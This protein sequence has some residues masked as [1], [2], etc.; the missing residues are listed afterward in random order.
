M[1]LAAG[2]GTR[3]RPLTDHT[4]KALLDVGGVPIIERVAR[5]L[6][7]A[8]A[9]R[10]II[11]TAH[12][13]EQIEAYVRSRDGFGVEAVFSR[14][15]PGP[16]ETG[17][18]LLV[19]QEHF[20]GDAPFFLHNA[21]ILSDIPLG[22]VHAAHRAAGDPL[23]TVAVLDRPTSRKLLFDDAGLLGR[24]DEGKGLDLRVRPPV[25]Q[26]AAI[27]FAGIHVISPRIFGLLTERGAFS[28]LDPYL[29]LADAGERVLPFR[30]DGHTWI[31]IGRPEQ[32]EQARQKFG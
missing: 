23:A 29:R 26:V 13:A 27:P 20:R 12:L 25:G 7:A 1:I 5:R 17:G 6:I 3:L 32:L 2:L 28:I 16:L 21:D 22:D 10:L 30:V 18:A 4:P 19:A 8:G 9:D 31:D 15:D 14:E 24:T 11:N